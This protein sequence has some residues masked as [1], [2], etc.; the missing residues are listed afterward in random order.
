VQALGLTYG[1]AIDTG[2]KQVR[3]MAK[4]FDERLTAAEAG[5][6]Y[7]FPSRGA[8]TGQKRKRDGSD[9]SSVSKRRKADDSDGDDSEI[10]IDDDE[11]DAGGKSDGSAG[12]ADLSDAASS[13]A[14]EEEEEEQMS[15]DEL[16]EKIKE[17]KEAIK[18]G[19]EQ[20]N[21]ARKNRK[22]AGDAIAQAKREEAAAQKEK[23]AFCSLK[24]SAYSQ[25]VLQEDF[26]TGLKDLDDV[27]A[28]E[29]DPNAFDPTIN[30]RGRYCSD[31]RSCSTD[32]FYQT[33]HQSNCRFTQFRL[34]TMSASRGRS[35]V[36]ASRPA[37]PTQQTPGSPTSRTGATRL[38]SARASAPHAPST[39][40][41]ASSPS[42]SRRTS[43]ALAT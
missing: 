30:L 5:E 36:T 43:L 37:S 19:R 8:K 15:L 25:G 32:S 14:D 35:R 29:R 6:P 1:L 17:T 28:E 9:N 31:D 38:R 24:R 23:N 13:D 33:M 34:A 27:A 26:R 11:S 41:S 3:D 39:S 21:I 10:E 40:T 16:K 2:L 7:K 20:L 12:P 18:V 22:A 42:R 4:E